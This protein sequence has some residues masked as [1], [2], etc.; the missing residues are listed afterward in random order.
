MHVRRRS[1]AVVNIRYATVFWI[2][3]KDATSSRGEGGGEM[4]MRTSMDGEKSG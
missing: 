2:L 1:A 3:G 4:W